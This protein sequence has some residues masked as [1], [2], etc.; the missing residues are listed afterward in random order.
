MIRYPIISPISL[1]SLQILHKLIALRKTK[2]VQYKFI[3]LGVHTCT[4]PSNIPW[5][6]THFCRSKY[7]CFL[8]NLHA[9]SQYIHKIGFLCPLNAFGGWFNE[10]LA[11]PYTEYRSH[12][13]QPEREREKQLLM[14]YLCLNKPWAC[15]NYIVI[16]FGTNVLSLGQ[17][18]RGVNWKWP[19]SRKSRK[20]LGQPRS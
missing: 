19:Q 2:T 13:E 8:S 15:R 6:I 17:W 11:N 4:M 16:L 14:E 18:G 10:W 5:F 9:W 12:R 7:I 3:F 1:R 20:V